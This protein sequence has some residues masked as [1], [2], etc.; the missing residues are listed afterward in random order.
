MDPYLEDPAFWQDFHRS[1]ITYCRDALLDSL[2]DAY[3]ARIDEQVRLI[4]HNEERITT[5]LPDVAIT[6]H[7]NPGKAR[8][9]TSTGSIATLEPVIIPMPIQAEE[10]RESWIEILHRPDRSLVTVIEV[11]SP[12]NKNGM[13]YWEYRNKRLNLLEQRAN[14][15]EL[16]LLLRGRRN[17]LRNP[18]PEGDYYAYVVR[19]QTRTSVDVYA[20]S[21]RN[22]LPTIPVPLKLPDPDIG[23]NIAEVFAVTYERGRY[24][25]SLPYQ[26]P[27]QVPLE[28]ESM[29]WA[30]ECGASVKT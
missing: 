1:F 12:A 30:T 24:R 28:G 3:E 9:I 20:W 16:D 8:A 22:P 17:E 2:P 5:R 7:S 15:V 14:R 4:E 11:L 19:A 25:R 18:L 26:A 29:K 10:V 13:G 27:P 6:R 21:L 23:L